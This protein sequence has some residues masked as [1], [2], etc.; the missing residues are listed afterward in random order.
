MLRRASQLIDDRLDGVVLRPLGGRPFDN[1]ADLKIPRIQG[2]YRI[3]IWAVHRKL[4]FAGLKT[5]RPIATLPA[6][7]GKVRQGSANV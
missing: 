4:R 5:A 2:V 6:R 1:V 7:P 3:P